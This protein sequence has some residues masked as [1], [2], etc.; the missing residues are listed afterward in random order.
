MSERIESWD[1][2]KLVLSISLCLSLNSC[3]GFLFKPNKRKDKGP[4]LG[5]CGL[6]TKYGVN[7]NSKQIKYKVEQY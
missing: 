1:R 3:K 4:L 6:S 5:G 2:P 7:R